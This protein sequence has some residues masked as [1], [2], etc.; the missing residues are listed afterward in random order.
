VLAAMVFAWL[1][2][3]PS[4]IALINWDNAAYI[5]DIASG[6]YDWSHMP[7]SS[8]L[9]IGQ[10]YMLGVWLAQALGGTVVDGF[11]IVNA[12]AFALACWV[13]FDTSQ[14]LSGSRWQALALTGLWATAWVNFHY[15]LILEDNFLF[16]APCAALL[17]TCVLRVGQ[18]RP[19][20]SL[21]C[22]MF[23]LL[24][25]LGSYQAL[26]YI[27]A[28][29]YTALLGPGRS[30]R[31]RLRDAALVL[32]GLVGTLLVWMAVIVATSRLT[33]KAL[34]GAVLMGPVPNYLPRSPALLL[35]YI[36]DGRSLLET[37]GNGV[38]WNLSFHAYKIPFAPPLGLWT[39]GLVAALCLLAVFVVATRW[40]WRTRDWGPHI[41]AA[42]LLLL[43]FAT[44]V[45][46]DEVEY[47]GLKRYDFLPLLFVF[48]AAA[49]L[50]ELRQRAA[51]RVYSAVTLALALVVIPTQLALGLRWT[52]LEQ[53]R[54]QTTA[55]WNRFPHPES[56]QYGRE[57][58][59]WFHYFRDLNRAH[60]DA[61]ALVFSYGELA[62]STWNYEIT[63]AL[64]SEVRSHLVLV[65]D[66]MLARF[67]P[68][69]R[70]VVPRLVH[71][72]RAD[73]PACAW[74]SEP[75]RELLAGPR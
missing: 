6:A 11:R 44:S 70:R 72:K 56:M 55:S 50:G 2:T 65:D 68:A 49:L 1:C 10:E 25:V 63:G 48:L 33:W 5:A 38:F 7:W 18:W 15:H 53:R 61:C 45:H 71:A 22:G 30:L 8:H 14:R 21:L 43:S 13:L 24:A 3:M 23:C 29:G 12:V 20:D 27:F 4:A 69:Q 41:M 59:S 66:A 74:V 9:G 16:L 47:T 67:R 46:K 37:L 52:V 34:G 28:A 64:Y 40:S 51:A 19:R 57:G 73:I 17:R 75:A 36:F 39:L 35:K 54:Y 31:Q 26:P 32:G 62:D 42:T 58:K 60:R